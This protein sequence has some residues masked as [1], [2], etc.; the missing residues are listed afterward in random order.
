VS[1]TAP[2]EQSAS[3]MQLTPHA[4][5]SLWHLYGK[6]GKLKSSWHVETSALWQL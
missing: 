5:L 2:G 1:H 3:V 4:L 6:H